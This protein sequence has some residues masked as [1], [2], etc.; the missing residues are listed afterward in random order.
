MVARLVSAV[1]LVAAG[2]YLLQALKLPL[3]SAA[4][5]GAGFYPVAIAVFACV[6]GLVATAQA[7][8]ASGAPGEVATA[9]PDAAGVRRRV[10]ITSLALV[11][12]PLVMPWI[13]YPASAAAFV[14]AV[15]RGLGSRWSS[16]IAIGVA[17]AAASQYL[18]AVLLDV[19]LPRGPW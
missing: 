5:P 18:F 15:M 8:L 9:D 4:R 13:G 10:V 2:F 7:F 12:F 16:A 1:V 17:A 14:I 3:G 19:P 6:V 11:A